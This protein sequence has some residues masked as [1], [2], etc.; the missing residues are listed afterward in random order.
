[1]SDTNIRY[2]VSFDADDNLYHVNDSLR[3]TLADDYNPGDT[4]ILVT[5]DLTTL[6]RWPATGIITLTEQCSDIQYRAISFMYTGINTT[7]GYISG[8]VLMSEFT[9]VFKPKNITHVTCNVMAEHHNSLKDAVIAIQEFVGV[10]GTTDTEP[11]GP[12]LEGRINFLRNVVLQPRA[13]FEADRQVGNI[14]LEVTFTDRSFRLGTDGTSSNVTIEWDFGDNT[15]SIVSAVTATSNAPDNPNLY[16]IDTD[17][18]S[19]KKTYYNAGIFDV[20]LTVTNDF[21][22][23]QIVFPDFI[24]ARIPAPIEATM[25]FP[26]PTPPGVMTPG[27]LNTSTPT[28]YPYTVVPTIRS[29]IN[30]L[31]DINID[32]GENPNTPGYSYAGEPLNGSHSALDPIMSYTWA[33]GDDLNHPNALTTKAAYSVGGIYDLKLRVDTEFGAYRITTY[34]NAID[35]IEDTNMWMWLYT[36]LSLTNVRAYEYGLISESFKVKSTPALYMVTRDASFLD[37]VPETARQKSEFRKNTGYATW[38]TGTSG[39]GSSV[40]LYWASGR[41]VAQPATV[42]TI[43]FVEYNAFQD[44]FAI[45]LSTIR[46]WNWASFSSSSMAYFLFGAISTD[47]QPGQS[48]T[49]PVKLQFD[50][51]AQ[52]FTTTT[53]TVTDFENGAQELLQNP[54]TFTGGVSDHGDF[55]VT[56][57]AW[58]G[59]TGYIARNDSVGEFLK[60]KSFYRT[61]GSL[62]NPVKTIRKL[63]DIQGPSKPEGELGDLSTGIYMFNNSGSISAYNESTSVWS[64]GGPGI[65]SVAYRS[66]QDTSVPNYDD[67]NNTMM[68]ATDHDHRAYI[69]FDYSSNVYLKFSELDLTFV[70]LGARPAGT[71]WMIGI[72]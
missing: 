28:S 71:Q 1:M 6:A 42:E 39:A 68:V 33:L 27:I 59:N 46:P 29:P 24:N 63:I 37:A 51:L 3:L 19:I 70:T 12:T 35:I 44:S 43:N 72:Y 23:D 67:V 65:N 47:Q 2:P 40:W 18:G 25:Y 38:G 55:S 69:T 26:S 22:S 8:L 13:W 53:L 49:N 66:L 34:K 57:T 11:F 7:T 52:T 54:A 64:T 45:Q 10:K 14:P 36:D 41:Q 20:T 56:R 17:G 21:G 48:A 15:A 50:S 32:A 60:I 58:K 62:G 16:V 61:E 9:D 4:R 30:T 31:I 5:G